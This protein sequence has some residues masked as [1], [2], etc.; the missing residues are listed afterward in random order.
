MQ[1][2]LRD[3]KAQRMQN[4]VFGAVL[5]LIGASLFFVKREAAVSVS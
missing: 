2:L 4:R 3:A 1:D 5:V